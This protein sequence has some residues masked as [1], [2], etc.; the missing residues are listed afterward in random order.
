[1]HELYACQHDGTARISQLPFLFFTQVKLE[2]VAVILFDDD[3]HNDESVTIAERSIQRHVSSERRW[4]ASTDRLL[5]MMA[6]N[7]RCI[8]NGIRCLQLQ[9]LSLYGSS[10]QY[11][12]PC[13]FCCIYRSSL[14]TNLQLARPVGEHL[15]RTSWS[16]P[17]RWAAIQRPSGGGGGGGQGG[18]SSCSRPIS[19]THLLAAHY[20]YYCHHTLLLH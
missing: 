8:D 18:K 5:A 16:T 7:S 17:H 6:N 19:V 13:L 11:Y 15:Q 2:V 20:P 1:M 12:C 4:A 9:F 14:P 3:N 10:W